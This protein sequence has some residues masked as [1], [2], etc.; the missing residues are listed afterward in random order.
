MIDHL[1]LNLVNNLIKIEC[2]CLLKDIERKIVL[3]HLM[4]LWSRK[5]LVIVNG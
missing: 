2:L 1:S 3:N 4:S 5:I